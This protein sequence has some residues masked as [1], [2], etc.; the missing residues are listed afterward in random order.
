[1]DLEGILDTTKQE[2]VEVLDN[3]QKYYYSYPIP[4]KDG[5]KRWLDAPIGKLKDWQDMILNKLLYQFYVHPIAYGFVPGRCPKDMAKKHVEQ[6]ILVAMDIYNFFNSIDAKLVK[7][8]LE[9]IIENNNSIDTSQYRTIDLKLLVDLLTYKGSIPQGAST[10][11]QI[12]NLVMLKADKVLSGVAK[13]IDSSNCVVTRYADDIVFS[14]APEPVN[15]VGMVLKGTREVLRTYG[16]SLNNK[17]IRVMR[18]HRRQKVLGIVVNEKVN[19]PRDQRRKFRAKLHNL[20]MSQ[21]PIPP[22]QEQKL[23]GKIEWYRTLNQ[24]K[25]NQFSKELSC[26]NLMST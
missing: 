13:N 8:T 11:P 1:M 19:I 22:L 4:K 14:T 2:I 15:F 9:F 26:L 5:S 12:S 10:S 18:K 25:G 16:F 7:R 3:K 21:E 23:R 17:K 6:D 20:K 24:K